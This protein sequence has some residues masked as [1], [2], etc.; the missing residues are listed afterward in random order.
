M[1]RSITSVAKCG[2]EMNAIPMV[3]AGKVG[4]VQG[5][6][7]VGRTAGAEPTQQIEN[8]T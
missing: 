3:A 8:T 4:L 7:V 2:I 1:M 6:I 5:G